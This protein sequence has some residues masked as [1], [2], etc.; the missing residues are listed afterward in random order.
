MNSLLRRGRVAAVVGLAVA[1]VACT[2]LGRAVGSSKV[3]PDEFRVVTK[4]PLVLP[5]EYNV[6]PPRPGERRPQELAP[7]EQARR[8]VLGQEYARRASDGEQL[9]VAKAGGAEADPVIRQRVDIE[10]GGVTRKTDEFTNLLLFWRGSEPGGGVL[11]PE[12]E[13]RRL[14]LVT[15]VTGEDEEVIIDRRTG[16]KLPGL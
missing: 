7:S 16:L 12:A 3:A 11:D 5:P 1:V 15:A 14:R 8:A 6:R 13:A 10:A 2:S 9:L 4:A